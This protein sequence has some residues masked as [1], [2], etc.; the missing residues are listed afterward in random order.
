MPAL[1]NLDFVF[2]FH[3]FFAE[4]SMFVRELSFHVTSFENKFHSVDESGY[5]DCFVK[6][7]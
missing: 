1:E 2:V 6:L 3:S 4:T 5:E 7:S